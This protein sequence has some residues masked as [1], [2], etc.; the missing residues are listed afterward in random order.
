M[1]NGSISTE[2]AIRTRDAVDHAVVRFADERK[3]IAGHSLDE[4]HL[5]QRP[6]AIER[7][8]HDP[9][10]Q[11]LEHAPVAGLRQR[12]MAHVVGEAEAIVVHPDRQPF[13]RQ[14][15][16]SLAKAR[17]QVQPRCDAGTD[18]LDVDAALGG[19]QRSGV[20]E[21]HA[22]DVHVTAR[23]LEADE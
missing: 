20:E 15:G 10:H 6:A 4:P 13:I 22:A 9:S 3:T 11:S 19:A 2:R 12:G 23:V 21:H 1:G 18:A 17:H 7:L 8:R 5:P 16:E 14:I